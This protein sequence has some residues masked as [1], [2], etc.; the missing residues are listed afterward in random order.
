VK[1]SAYAAVDTMEE[2]MEE[3]Q[4]YKND[5]TT[6]H[7]VQGC[8]KHITYSKAN[9]QQE[10]ARKPR[11]NSRRRRYRTR[12][13]TKHTPIQRQQQLLRRQ[14]EQQQKQSQQKQQQQ[15][16]LRKMEAK[17]EFLH[18]MKFRSGR[19]RD[20]NKQEILKPTRTRIGACSR[21]TAQRKQQKRRKHKLRQQ[22]QYQRMEATEE[23]AYN[24]MARGYA[25]ETITKPPTRKRLPR[26]RNGDFTYT[27][28][29]LTKRKTQQHLM[30]MG[31]LMWEL[32]ELEKEYNKERELERQEMEV[33]EKKKQLLH[34]LQQKLQRQQQQQQ[35]EQGRELGAQPWVENKDQREQIMAPQEETVKTNNEAT[36]QTGRKKKTKD[37]KKKKKNKSRRG[38]KKHT[39]F[40]IRTERREETTAGLRFAAQPPTNN[41]TA[42][43]LRQALDR[44]RIKR[45][46]DKSAYWR[47]KK[48]PP[49]D[50]KIADT[51]RQA[52]DL[53][54]SE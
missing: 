50:E 4:G 22:Q 11:E 52:L 44:E 39:R 46:Q 10:K 45:L 30:E 38:S 16:K 51:L 33:K 6:L 25:R 27:R 42:T 41:M 49:T 3:Q 23:R 24:R 54:K 37:K 43:T 29:R 15:Q 21:R 36:M 12:V 8:T 13:R 48:Q 35:E 40:K 7:H 26:T 19:E 17:E 18:N 34:E 47:A 1:R 5:P 9:K 53:D 14:E 31:K 28:M 2:H 32:S 20:E